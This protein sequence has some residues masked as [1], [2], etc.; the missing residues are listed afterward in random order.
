MK[1]RDRFSGR[2]RTPS[3]DATPL[4]SD[5]T[6]TLPDAF[7]DHLGSAADLTFGEARRAYQSVIFAFVARRVRPVEEAED[8]V[9]AVFVDAFRH[10]GRRKGDPR[11]WLLGIARRKVADSLRKRRTQWTLREEDAVADALGDFV[12]RAEADRAAALV[13]RLPENERDA[14]L[15]QVLEELPIEEIAAVLGRSTKATNSLLGRARTR[16]RRL[17]AKDEPR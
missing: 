10:W 4:E 12:R 13:A 15:M 9:A 14:L 3:V 1:S 16:V 2:A 5:L 11:L 7:A 8:V 17:A 6:D